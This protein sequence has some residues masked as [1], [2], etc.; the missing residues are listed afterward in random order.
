MGG[1]GGKTIDP[2]SVPN[3]DEATAGTIERATSSS[4]PLVIVFADEANQNSDT[5]MYGK[6]LA[7]ISKSE[8]VFIKVPYTKDRTK[9][10]Q[11]G[12]SV[13]PQSKIL[14]DN[15]SREY[16]VTQYPTIL[17]T[18]GNGNECMRFTKMPTAADLR[19]GFKRVVDTMDKANK[20]LSGNLE[21]ARKAW[22][23]KDYSKSLKAIEKN[24][25]D[26]LYGLSAQEDT[27]RLFNEI[28]DS[29][30]EEVASLK[31]AGDDAATKKI[32]EIRGAFKA[33]DKSFAKELEGSV[34]K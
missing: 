4:L 7:D 28:R 26:G 32:N 33:I 13:V 16:K 21:T 6:D 9:P 24:F 22:Q 8:A 17:V 27:I 25:K 15:Q 18:D 20:R 34:K 10:P 31:R 14:S 5:L 2:A 23:T 12:E 11:L 29:A 19:S 1:G 3:W 30:R